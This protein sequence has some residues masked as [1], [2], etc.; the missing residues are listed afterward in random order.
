MITTSPPQ[1]GH[2]V[3]LALRRLGVPWI[4]DLR[5]GWTYDPPRGAW[6]TRAQAAAD[7]AL[8]RAVL[9]RADRLVAVT[10]PI[11]DDLAERLGRAVAVV[12][13]GFDP[14][15]FG[16]GLPDADG[17]LTPAATRSCTPAGRASRAGR[18]GR[19]SMAWSSCAA[20]G[21]TSPIGSTSSSRG[22]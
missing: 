12:T 17:L 1:S 6:P 18:R 4:A 8:E 9:A 19:S 15:E 22:L 3:G 10:R 14:D 21:P 7:A 13:N 16:D 2:L 11:A 5:D 20:A